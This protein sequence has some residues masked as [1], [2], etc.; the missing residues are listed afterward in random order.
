MNYLVLAMKRSGHHVIINWLKAFT[1]LKHYNNTCFGWE[2][3]KLL[4]KG[5]KEAKEG[6]ANIE[7]FNIDDW[8]KFDFPSFPFLKN[9][10]VIV[11]VRSPDNWLASCY[12][13]KFQDNEEW[14]DVYKYLDKE[15]INDSKRKSPSRIDLYIS[16]MSSAINIPDNWV[17]INYDEFIRGRTYRENT[18]WLFKIKFNKDIDEAV[19]NTPT[20]FGGGSSFGNLNVFKRAEQ[21]SADNEYELLLG[22]LLYKLSRIRS[23][24]CFQ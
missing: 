14:K 19:I 18:A 1:G 17:L 23:N 8:E 24:K 6:I 4:M 15:Y 9:C 5:K 12:Q 7:D 2:D 20:S 13:R 22:M 11:V 16:L 21:F 10:K 3:K